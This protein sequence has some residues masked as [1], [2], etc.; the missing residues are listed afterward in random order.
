MAQ[1][2]EDDQDV[3]DEADGETM[4]QIYSKDTLK[5]FQSQHSSYVN[6]RNE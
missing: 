3:E 5:D 4:A 6:L 2:N 1:F